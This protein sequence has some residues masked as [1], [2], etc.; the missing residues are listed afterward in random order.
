[1]MRPSTFKVFG[2]GAEVRECT[3]VTSP[4]TDVR[5]QRS[6]TRGSLGESALVAG[7]TQS[8]HLSAQ[9]NHSRR[10]AFVFFRDSS[11]RTV[12]SALVDKAL[13]FFIRTQTQHFFAATS[14]ISLPQIEEHDFE[15]G[16]EFERGLRRKHSDQ[17]LGNAVWRPTCKRESRSF[18]HLRLSH[19]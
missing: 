1:M 13:K 8:F 11:D 15:Q 18:R 17:L 9:H 16:L 14:C 7:G 4:E 10:D 5:S 12:D 3:G 2:E 6:V 19:E